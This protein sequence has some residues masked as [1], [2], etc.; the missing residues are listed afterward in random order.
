MKILITGAHFTPAQAIVEELQKLEKVEIIYV[1]RKYTLEGD[2]ALSAESQI[3]PTM[4]VKFIPIVT[5]RL[6]RY[7]SLGTIISLFKLPIGFI[8]GFWIVLTQ[9]PDVVVSFGGY[10]AVPVVISAWLLNIPVLIHEQTLVTGL[11]N[12]ISAL[13]ATK[14]AVTI[15]QEY[16][17][18]KQ[19]VILTGNPIR[20]EILNVQKASKRK[21]PIILITGGN[22]GSHFINDLISQILDQ[23]TQKYYLVHQTGDSKFQDFE[24]LTERKSQIKNPENYR[25]EKF[26]AGEEMGKIMKSADLVVSR[27]GANTLLELAYLGTPTLIIPISYLYKNEQLVNAKYFT[28]AGLG[29]YLNQEGL[30]ASKLLDQINEMLRKKEQYRKSAQGAK[31][32]VILDAAKKITQEILILTQHD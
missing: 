14:I 20:K 10:V 12:S 24:K 25:L 28:K 16:N 8:Q 2:K 18:P 15:N 11:A 26:I 31:N 6:R 22:Q 13:F 23:L 5:G 29:E 9:R 30:S 21:L 32:V 4:G 3:M 1:G 17:F 19:K 7:L 27:A